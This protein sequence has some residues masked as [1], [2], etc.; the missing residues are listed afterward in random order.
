MISLVGHGTAFADFAHFP[1]SEDQDVDAEIDAMD[2]APRRHGAFQVYRKHKCE[3]PPP[4]A[5]MP[6]RHSATGNRRLEE[7]NNLLARM[8]Y[9]LS[10]EL[11]QVQEER[12]AL[13]MKLEQLQN[14]Y[15]P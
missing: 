5:P 1:G 14:R 11:A 4:E 7:H 15:D 8:C 9:E 12:N 2:S 10:Q 3:S 13:Q 6:R